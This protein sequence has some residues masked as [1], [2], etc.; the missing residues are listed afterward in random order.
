MRVRNTINDEL[1]RVS[2]SEPKNIKN[3]LRNWSG[4]ESLSLKGDTV[5]LCILA[6]LKKVTGIDPE[7]YDRHSREAFDEGYK[8]GCL[9]YYQFMSIAYTLVLGYSQEEI[10]YVMGVVD[11]FVIN[12]NI[13]TGI[14]RIIKVLEGG[15]DEDKMQAGG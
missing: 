8:D 13:H 6:D 14:K 15:A 7:L 2:Y 5:A 1:L 9:T 11:H 3:F 10:A 12:K 4:L